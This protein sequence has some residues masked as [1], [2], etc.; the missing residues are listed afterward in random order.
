MVRHGSLFSQILEVFS[1]REF[2]SLVRD[3]GTQRYS[4]GFS[5]WEHFVALLFCQLAQAKSLREISLGLAASLGKITHLGIKRAPNKSTLAYANGH[6]SWTLYEA[7]FHRL[8]RVLKAE[9]Q[10]RHRLKLP[11]KLYSLDATVI[12]LCLS[13]FDWS[14]YRSAKG[15]V[16]LHLV[17]DHDGYLPR[18]ATITLARK[19][20]VPVARHLAF[21][22]GSVV[23]VDR[24]YWSVDLFGQWLRDQVYFVTR[25]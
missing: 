25:M 8:H 17:L 14:H 20:D 1:R 23:V 21:P 7:L 4:K 5:S 13:V 11:G 18:F 2:E 22:S 15:A 6:R 19:H 10:V 12:S 3:I 24:G 9:D 16:K